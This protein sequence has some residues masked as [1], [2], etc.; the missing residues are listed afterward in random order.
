VDI[1]AHLTGRRLLK[2]EGYR[3]DAERVFGAAPATAS[4]SRSTARWS[5]SI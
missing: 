2:R 4:R 1:L 5:G 3:D